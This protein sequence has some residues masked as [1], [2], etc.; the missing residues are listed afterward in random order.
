MKYHVTMAAVIFVPFLAGCERVDQAIDTY[1]NVK[2]LKADFQKQSEDIRKGIAEKT[3]D[4]K[5]RIR[6]KV[7]MTSRDSARNVEDPEG[8]DHGKDDGES[9]RDRDERD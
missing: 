1:K 4:Y 5:D 8:G 2:D 7:G 9:R 3:E 6:K